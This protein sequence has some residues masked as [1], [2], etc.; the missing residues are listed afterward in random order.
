MARKRRKRDPSLGDDLGRWL[1]SSITFSLMP[2]ALRFVYLRTQVPVATGLW[3]TL[4][5]TLGGGDLF[6]IGCCMGGAALGERI[7][8]TP[9]QPRLE[10][11]LGQMCLISTLI[12]VC[13]YTLSLSKSFHDTDRV[14]TLSCALYILILLIS[15]GLTFIKL[16]EKRSRR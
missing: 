15:A 7:G 1:G 2:L 14:A 6:L 5:D 11:F 13:F 16:Q 10:H 4:R 9:I 3:R 12:S 8:S